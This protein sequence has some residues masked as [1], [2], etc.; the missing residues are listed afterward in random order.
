MSM[1]VTVAP[2]EW[3]GE[4]TAGKHSQ[5]AFPFLAAVQPAKAAPAL[6]IAACDDVGAMRYA[7]QCSGMDD[8]EVAD[9]LAISHGYM[10]KVLHGTA[11][12]YGKRL[13]RFMR[14]TGS[15]APLQWLAE[16]MGCEVVVKDARAAEVAA[17][18][19]RL[20]ELTSRRAA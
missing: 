10:S 11:G 8:F 2:T 20:A 19:S 18:Q 1:A 17:L 5:G 13:V 12:L 6:F 14:I 9:E 4:E 16:Q 7:T 15:I 3:K